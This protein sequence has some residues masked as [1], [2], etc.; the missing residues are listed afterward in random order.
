MSSRYTSPDFAA[1]GLITIDTQRDVLDGGLLE[2]AGTSTALEPM[3][4]LV[5]AF[6][7]AARPIVHIVRIYRSDGSNVDLCRRELVEH[8]ARP[9]AP[10]ALGTQL[11]LDLLPDPEVTLDDEL[12][13]AGGVQRL[14]AE[15]AVIYKP[16]WGAF[17]QTSLESHLRELKVNTLVFCGCNYPNCPRTSIYEASE[18][19][20]RIVLA[21]DAVSGLYERAEAE[22][23]DIGVQ[24]MSTRQV[25]AY[26]GAAPAPR[27]AG[28]PLA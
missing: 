16:R 17:Y 23:A 26:L 2:I 25:L 8:G 24:L 4:D 13:L 18:R 1:A 9:L 20:F 14:G 19:D 3:R 22:L 10:G 27:P 15:E 6:R 28:A 21:L 5:R 7:A 12:L 11:A